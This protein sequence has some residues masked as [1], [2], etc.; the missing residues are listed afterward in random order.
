MAD[1]KMLWTPASDARERTRIGVYLT[2]LERERGMAFAD[3]GELLGWST[4]DVG[5]FWSSVWEHF[6]VRSATD[7]GPALADARMP[8]ARWFPDARLNWAE[9]CLRLAGR[10]DDDI[11]VIAR[12]QSRDRVT[13]TVRAS[14]GSWWPARAQ[15]SSAWASV[16]V[17][18]SR[19]TCRTC[20]RR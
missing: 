1:P 5:G 13:L 11:V 7:P 9:H 10:T 18:G 3:Y 17:T 4:D 19:R 6:D 12:S 8:G 15:G 16:A 2:W 20:R 14:C